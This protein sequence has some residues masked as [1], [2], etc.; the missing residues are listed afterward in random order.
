MRG[1]REGRL[2]LKREKTICCAR[3]NNGNLGPGTAQSL[4]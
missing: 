2:L 3:Y 4:F 1:F